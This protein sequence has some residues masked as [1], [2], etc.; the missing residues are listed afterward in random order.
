MPE[1]IEVFEL[2]RA[3]AEVSP[4]PERGRRTSTNARSAVSTTAGQPGRS[5]KATEPAPDGLLAWRLP[6]GGPELSRWN[7]L[8]ILHEPAN[9]F[10]G[11]FLGEPM[12]LCSWH[13]QAP[14]SE[15][16]GVRVVYGWVHT[17]YMF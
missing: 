2:S 7:L 11:Q 10:E 14:T 8:V 12:V 5:S 17:H 13:G 16:A 6:G 15:L 4:Q 9:R 3:N 1:L